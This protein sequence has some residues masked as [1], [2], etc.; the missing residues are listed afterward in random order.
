MEDKHPKYVHSSSTTT[1]LLY[2]EG[3]SN[4][5]VDILQKNMQ[6]RFIMILHARRYNNLSYSTLHHEVWS[7]NV[8]KY[9]LI[10]IGQPDQLIEVKL[11]ISV[12]LTNL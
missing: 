6:L 4:N 5:C 12:F 1:T 7:T 11:F 9:K 8:F 3:I 10:R 2:F